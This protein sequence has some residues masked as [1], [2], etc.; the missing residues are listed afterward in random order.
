MQPYPTGTSPQH[1]GRQKVTIRLETRPEYEPDG[2]GE[3][4][5][6][7][8]T[9]TLK[10]GEVVKLVAMDRFEFSPDSSVE[11]GSRPDIKP[12]VDVVV[13]I[14]MRPLPSMTDDHNTWEHAMALAMQVRDYIS[15]QLRLNVGL[16]VVIIPYSE[17][18]ATLGR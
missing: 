9:L 11:Y 10:V 8:Q 5:T 13:T 17:I 12:N 6:G 16:E 18:R 15:V 2:E 4:A 3:Q 14:M 1:P 7:G